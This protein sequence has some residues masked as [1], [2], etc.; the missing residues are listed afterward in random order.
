MQTART[1]FSRFLKRNRNETSHTNRAL[2]D[3]FPMTG[4]E[5]TELPIARGENKAVIK[6]FN[7]RK[8][9]SVKVIAVNGNQHSRALQGKYAGMKNTFSLKQLFVSENIVF[10]CTLLCVLGKQANVTT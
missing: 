2:S 9:Y 10:D 6:D 3:L 1:D 4:G 5:T 7:P 8:E